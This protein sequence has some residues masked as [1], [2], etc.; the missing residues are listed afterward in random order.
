LDKEENNHIRTF[1][2]KLILTELRSNLFSHTL[3]QLL[4]LK[5]NTHKLM[6]DISSSTI[7]P[8]FLWETI[9]DLYGSDHL[10]ILISM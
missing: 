9:D 10:P 3:E 5:L 7:A 2:H 4:I 1:A 8:E 6:R